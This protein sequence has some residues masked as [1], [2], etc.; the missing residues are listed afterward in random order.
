W[1][2]PVCTGAAHFEPAVVRGPVTTSAGQQ[3]LCE[4]S[5]SYMAKLHAHQSVLPPDDGYDP[6]RDEYDVAIFVLSGHIESVGRIFG[7][8]S[9]LWHSAGEPHGIRNV[10]KHPARYLVFE[11][12]TPRYP[13]CRRHPQVA[14]VG[15]TPETEREIVAQGITPLAGGLG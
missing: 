14:A 5:T 1:C 13:G 6:H 15:R 10:G 11:F 8:N 4:F 3:R 9:F 12:H 7:P 2:G